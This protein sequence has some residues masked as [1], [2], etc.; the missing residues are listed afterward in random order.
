MSR[1]TDFYIDQFNSAVNRFMRAYSK[2]T[3]TAY[4]FYG[5]DMCDKYTALQQGEY[6]PMFDPK[7]MYRTPAKEVVKNDNA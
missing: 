7:Y 3:C 6:N 4:D 1:T 2:H 5:C